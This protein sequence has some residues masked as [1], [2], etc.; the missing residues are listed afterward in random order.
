MGLPE[1]NK[2]VLFLNTVY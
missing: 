2:C 1:K